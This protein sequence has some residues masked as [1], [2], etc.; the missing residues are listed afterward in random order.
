MKGLGAYKNTEVSTSGRVKLIVMLYEGAINFLEI[1]KE[2]MAIGDVPGKAR[3]IDR[4]TAIVSELLC[5]LDHDKGGRIADYLRA[6]YDY[7]IREMSEANIKNDPKPLDVVISIL[8]ELKKGWE[9]VERMGI[10]RPKTGRKVS[11]L[12]QNT[13]SP[14]R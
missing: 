6:L 4:A 2:K 10:E 13:A 5:S 12:S 7:A 1:A 9:E 8:A 11:G 3:Y 14:M